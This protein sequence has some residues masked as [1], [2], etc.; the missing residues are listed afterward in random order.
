MLKNNLFTLRTVIDEYTFDKKKAPQNLHDLV[1][2]GYLRAVPFDPIAG[3]DQTWRTVMEDALTAVTDPARNLRRPQRF[4]SEEP[5]GHR[6]F[7][8]CALVI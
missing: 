6:L 1:T 2:E 8:L 4:G 3:T 7:G 5:R